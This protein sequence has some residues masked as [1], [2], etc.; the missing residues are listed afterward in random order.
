MPVNVDKN[1]PDFYGFTRYDSSG[2]KLSIGPCVNPG[3]E[4]KHCL[5]CTREILYDSYTNKLKCCYI[6]TGVDATKFK[7]FKKM[8]KDIDN[9]IQRNECKNC[10]SS[11]FRKRTNNFWINPTSGNSHV[12]L[13]ISNYCPASCLYCKSKYS[14]TWENEIKENDNI[15]QQILEQNN[16][17]NKTQDSEKIIKKIVD[18]ISKNI[19]KRACIGITGGEPAYNIIEEDHLKKIVTRFYS[20]NIVPR[21]TI[22]YDF[23]TSLNINEKR[24]RKIKQYLLSYCNRYRDLF[25]VLQIGI[26]STDDYFNFTR[27]GNNWQRFDKNL[28]LFLERTNFGIEF[29]PMY[30]N[31][32][33]PNLLDFIKYT[34]NLSFT[35]RPIHLSSAFALDYNAFNFNLLPKDHLQYVKTTRDYLD[36]NKIYFE[37]KESVYSS[38]DFMEYCFNHLSTSK[39]DYQEALEV[40]DYFK[41]KRQVDLQQINPTMYNHL[42]KMSAN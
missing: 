24:C 3:D 23:C 7:N 5:A 20:K 1:N 17:E 42:L 26:E 11:D 21:R 38:L 10:D 18:S 31:V 16:I 34:N 39:K 35:Y 29:K 4:N 9:G 33:L 13:E 6:N 36:N 41:R 30:N 37:N 19:N 14:S 8:I 32:A 28:K 15:P 25:I 12:E 40:F 27:Y 2:K 22:R